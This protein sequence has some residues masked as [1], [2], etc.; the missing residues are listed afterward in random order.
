MFDF[1]GTLVDTAPDLVR[2]ANLYLNSKGL[3]PL[4]EDQIRREI[5]MGLRRFIVEI[6]P[7]KNKD[8]DFR[9]KIEQEFIEVYEREFLSTPRLFD[10]AREFLQE[11]E[12]QVAIVSNKRERFIKPILKQLG[13]DSYPW[14][15]IVGGDTFSQM[16]P[17]PEPFLR[18]I[19][20]AGLSPEET[21][22]VGDGHPDVEGALAVGCRSVVVGFGYTASE[23]LINLGGTYAIESFDELLPLINR[24]T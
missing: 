4:S 22:M 10:G 17:H 12:G 8:E 11:F 19:E 15:R 18:V 7:E 6:Y 3:D 21:L 20:A 16:K 2:A 9:K 5:G 13:L 23:E 14:V 24:I 1:D